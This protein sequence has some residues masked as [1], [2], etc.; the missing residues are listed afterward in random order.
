MEEVLTGETID[1]AAELERRAAELLSQLGII[2]TADPSS[3]ISPAELAATIM[4]TLG[5]PDIQ[6][7]RPRLIPEHTIFGRQVA[8]DRET[9]VSGIAD[10]LA[11]APD[12]RVEVIVDW[13][14]DTVMNSSKLNHYRSQLDIYRKCTGA[15]R[16]LL[17]LM[18]SGSVNE[19]A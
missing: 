11:R 1:T 6:A 10:A 14:S 19:L 8:E 17:V 3:G 15:K 12:G 4:R 7:L 5:L 18:T 2:A 16:A 13:K 9:L